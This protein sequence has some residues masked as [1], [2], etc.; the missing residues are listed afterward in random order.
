MAEWLQILA[1]ALTIVATLLR[2]A[3][4]KV[5]SA[6]QSV[7]AT[8]EVDAIRLPALSRLGRWQFDRL[9]R[10]GAIVEEGRG[11][12]FFNASGYRAF[13]ARRRRRALVA[14]PILLVAVLIMWYFSR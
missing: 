9:Q 12:Y 8:S 11:R 5:V 4:V 13:Q 10:R 7:S 6:L 2:R 3:E 1:A 14:T